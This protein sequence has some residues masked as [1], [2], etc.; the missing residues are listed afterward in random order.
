M[1]ANRLWVGAFLQQL[2]GPAMHSQLRLKLADPLAICRQPTALARAQT[3]FKAP[4]DPVLTPP[5]VDR[6]LGDPEIH[7][8]VRDPPAGLDQ[9]QHATAELRRITPSPHVVLLEDNSPRVQNPD[10][11]EPGTDQHP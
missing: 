3:S 11:T 7:G 8:H 5:V 6:L 2:G 1:A 9:I 10:S 4:I